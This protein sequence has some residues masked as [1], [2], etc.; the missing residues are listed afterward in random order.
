MKREE[1]NQE[2]IDLV[3]SVKSRRPANAVCWCRGEYESEEEEQEHR[4]RT[5]RTLKTSLTV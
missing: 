5:T 3:L 2:A 1:Y 4:R